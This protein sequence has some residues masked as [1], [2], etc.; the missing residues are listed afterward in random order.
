MVG[1]TFM[2][3]CVYMDILHD[4]RYKQPIGST[5]CC[6]PTL[7]FCCCLIPCIPLPLTRRAVYYK[8]NKSID[9]VF[10]SIENQFFSCFC[11]PLALDDVRDTLEYIR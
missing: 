11:Y 4:N 2:P 9:G 8:A 3:C 10:A 7:E 5:E 6:L 1:N